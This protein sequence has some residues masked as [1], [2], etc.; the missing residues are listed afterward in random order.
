M[1]FTYKAPVE[2]NVLSSGLR[3]VESNYNGPHDFKV[4]VDPITRL[5]NK[6]V[7]FDHDGH[8]DIH[9]GTPDVVSDSSR[10]MIYLHS[11]NPNHIVLMAL[12]CNHED[13]YAKTQV[14]VVCEKYNMVYQRHEPMALD[15]V[16]DLKKCTIDSNGVVTYAWWKLDI[17]WDMMVAQGKSHRQ[18]IA[19]RLRLDILTADQIK[20]AN[21]CLEI[22][23]YVILNE[24]SKDTP[25][26]IA[27]PLMD[28]VCLKNSVRIGLPDNIENG[29]R[30][31]PITP[32]WGVVP[33][34]S[35]C[36]FEDEDFVLAAICP[37]TAEEAALL[38]PWTDLCPDHPTHLTNVALWNTVTQLM[39]ANDPDIELTTEKILETFKA[40]PDINTTTEK[41]SLTVD[42]ANGVL[43]N[44][45]DTTTNTHTV[46]EVDGVAANVG[47]V[48]RGSNGGTFVINADGS[49][50]FTPGTA[51]LHLNDGESDTTSVTYTNLSSNGE[52]H[53]S[54]LTIVVTG[55]T[56]D[57]PIPEFLEVTRVE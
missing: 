28:A 57:I 44:D 30:V 49:Y 34:D 6:G 43:S 17:T 10:E 54:T 42:A 18:Q 27:F 16:Y 33:H 39:I 31:L 4:F 32:Q 48:V 41:T 35:A 38:T 13:H 40:Y 23:D 3:D 26:K 20:K 21:Y 55:V 11:H 45:P 2:Y 47:S 56:D 19:E 7:E 12:I 36:H 1:K 50:R 22:I 14:E 37:I 8:P 51:F 52:S 25:W 9:G 15:H 24:I 46:S 5:V 29:S 53:S